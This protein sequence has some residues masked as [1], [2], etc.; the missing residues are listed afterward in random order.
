MLTDVY[1]HVRAEITHTNKTTHT[2]ILDAKENL[3]D[4]NRMPAFRLNACPFVCSLL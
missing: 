4:L 3:S 2:F 1:K